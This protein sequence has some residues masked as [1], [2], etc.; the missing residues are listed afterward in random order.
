MAEK[1]VTD[2][3]FE[4]VD[5]GTGDI[6]L[7]TTTLFASL[8]AFGVASYFGATSP[9]SGQ[10][11]WVGAAGAGFAGAVRAAWKLFPAL[12]SRR[13]ARKNGGALKAA[14]ELPKLR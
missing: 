13:R 2:A 4:V 7:Q 6:A 10:A 1:R 8:L 3:E 9:P 14:D 5:P 12:R 11:L